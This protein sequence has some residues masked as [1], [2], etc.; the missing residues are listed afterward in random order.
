MDA[1]ANADTGEAGE[2]KG[3]RK[4]VVGTALFLLQSLIVIDRKWF[5]EILVPH[6]DVLAA[7]QAGLDV[8]TGGRQI[9]QQTAQED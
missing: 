3:V 8:V 7:N 9:L 1:F 5:G 6:R 4:Q 2:Q